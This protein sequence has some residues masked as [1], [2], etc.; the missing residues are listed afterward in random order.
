MSTGCLPQPKG[1]NILDPQ[2]A[3][4]SPW[5][6][7]MKRVFLWNNECVDYGGLLQKRYVKEKQMY[8]RK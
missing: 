5:I 8:S 6:H 2:W 4:L 7:S 3:Y 1:D